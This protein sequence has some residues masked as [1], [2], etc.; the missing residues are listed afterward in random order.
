MKVMTK[1]ILLLITSLAIFSCENE[2]ELMEL[3]V[4]DFIIEIPSDWKLEEGQG[5][6]SFVRQIKIN[7]HEVISIDLGWYSSSLNVDE[8]THD[9]TFKKIDNKEAKIVNPKNFTKGT[10]G[11]YF[12][13]L[14]AQKTKL[15][16]SGFDL[17]EKNQRLFLNA[18]ETIRFK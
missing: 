11:V 5:Y 14:D 18:I 6:D 12:D 4:G 9:I 7:E 13:S 3:P 8:S 17:S 16:M 2:L 15:E 1:I 10:T